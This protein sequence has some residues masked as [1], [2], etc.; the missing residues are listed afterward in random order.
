MASEALS[1]SHKNREELRS[2]QSNRILVG[3]HM[4][5]IY[6]V[7][8]VCEP[9]AMPVLILTTLLGPRVC[10]QL[11]RDSYEHV[12]ICVSLSDNYNYTFTLKDEREK[13]VREGKNYGT[14]LTVQ[15]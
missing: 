3:N 1:S 6:T 2:A 15:V 5:T 12:C 4:Y 13:G 8:V 14:H 9:S 7:V 11:E 10:L